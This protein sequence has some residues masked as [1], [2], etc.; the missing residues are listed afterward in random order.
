MN[1]IL[2]CYFSATG[3]TKVVAH[4]I[5]KAIGGDLFEIVPSIKYTENDL[6]WEDKTSRSSIEMDNINGRP[7]IL[8]KVE[9]IDNYNTILI[10]YPIWWYTLPRIINTF[11]EENNL[12]NKK[13]YLFATSGGSGIE[14]SLS[15]LKDTYKD[16][17]F[18]SAKRFS[19]NEDANT[20]LNWLK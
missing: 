6:D 11:I 2:I 8:N 9:N 18:I 19:G 17:N 7:K 13:I 10:G 15:D 14:K 3:K 4:N 16:L 20:Y 5:A 12:K 1:K